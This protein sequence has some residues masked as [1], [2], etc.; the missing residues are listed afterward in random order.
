MPTGLERKLPVI[1]F[2]VLLIMVAIGYLFYRNTGD[3]K[4]AVAAEKHTQEV[5]IHL[6]ETLTSMVDIETGMRGFFFNRDEELLDPYYKGKNRLPENMARLRVLLKD[7]PD[8]N[9]RLD[10]LQS[11]VDVR[12]ADADQKVEA[13]RNLS[14]EDTIELFKASRGKAKMDDVRAAVEAIKNEELKDLDASE[15]ELDRNLGNAFWILISVGTAGIL[16]LALANFVVFLEV[17]KRR[18][19]EDD[20][21]EANK[22]LEKRVEQRTSQLAKANKDLGE[23]EIFRRAV[24]DSLAAHIAVLDKEGN[25]LLVNEAWERFAESNVDDAAQVGTTGVGQNYLKVLEKVLGD[26]SIKA[27]RENLRAV[28]EGNLQTFTVE[29]E[30]H[31]K[32]EERWFLMQANALHSSTGGLVISHYNITDR[33][34][35][36]QSVKLSEEFN[37][38]IV[39]NSPDCVK[40]LELDG[41]MLSMNYP[42]MCLM[43]IDDL[44][45]F[46]GQQWTENWEGEGNEQA[47]AAVIK[48]RGGE[49]AFFE[50]FCR[51]AKG[52]P[53]WWEV[54]VAP[55]LNDLGKPHRLLVVS[56]EI[57]ERKK[58]HDEREEL[59]LS[60]QTARKE[61]EVANRLRDEFMAS[62]SHELRTPLNSI[63]G[64][65]RLLKGGMLDESISAKA[66]D[67]IIKSSETQNR[68][69]EDLLDVARLI[70][71]KLELEITQVNVV[72]LIS[73]S[74]EAVRP[75]VDARHISLNLEIDD[76]CRESQ[77]PGD[78]NRLQQ[79]VW[80][81][82]T[83]AVKFSPEGGRVNIGVSAKEG[84]VELEIA[85][86]GRGISPEFLPFVFERFRQDTSNIEKRSGL[87]LGLA[88]VRHLVELHGGSVGARSEGENK[89][90]VFTVRLPVE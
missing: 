67:T 62:V 79:V 77:I 43:E 21:M 65:A 88:I 26:E 7:D 85:D 20:L 81:L 22:G 90:S 35:A 63:L 13:R 8:Q 30:C 25:I 69:I 17:K 57:S 11:V 68:L 46:V 55:V 36:E 9:K 16:T 48:A 14:L 29:Y 40:V 66:V 23:S 12:L 58:A 41:A 5:I 80:N 70:S 1:L 27:V 74:I 39:E 89:G 4:A 49:A 56:R 2:F 73:N 87:G 44:Q 32:T 6:D 54:S 37:R 53:K 38:S 64:W 33:V 24:I 60:E 10:D 76:N 47:R 61:A 86:N 82:L 31:S 84:F 72:E 50:G 28:L 52:T 71:G 42:G 45:P 18:K 59:L 19:A 34:K 78:I 15:K 51:T 83:N 75:M 3:L